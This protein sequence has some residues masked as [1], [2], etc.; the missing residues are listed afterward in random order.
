METQSKNIERDNL[1]VLKE[2]H[3]EKLV[4]DYVK[5]RKEDMAEEFNMYPFYSFMFHVKEVENFLSELLEYACCVQKWAIFLKMAFKKECCN[6]GGNSEN[7][8]EFDI[9]SEI[10]EL[11]LCL[12]YNKGVI[13]NMRN[14]FFRT[15]K[16]LDEAVKKDFE[17]TEIEGYETK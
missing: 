15:E 7:E 5:K 6:S 3:V 4:K 16:L 13:E 8:N 17:I 2:Q 14:Y 12:A 9:F 11:F 10:S 1:D